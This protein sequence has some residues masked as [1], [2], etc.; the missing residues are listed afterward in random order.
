MPTTK[1]KRKAKRPR[2]PKAA[3]QPPGVKVGM[4][5]MPSDYLSK[6]KHKF[7]P[8]SHAEERLVRSHSYWICTTRADGRPHAMPVWGAWVEGAVYFGTGRDTIKAKNIA[9][10]P[11]IIVHLESGDDMVTMEGT[12]AEADLADKALCAKLNAEYKRKYKMPMLG[13]PGSIVYRVKPRVV[14]AWMEKTFPYN[15]TRWEFSE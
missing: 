14:L 13:M 8:W 6:D 2:N 12:A 3:V 15:S 1:P 11:A 9:Y 5:R 4:P 10:N 7:L